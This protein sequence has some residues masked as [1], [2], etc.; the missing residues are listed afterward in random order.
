MA[1]PFETADTAQYV[2]W[3]QAFQGD[4]VIATQRERRINTLSQE[5][6]AIY[7]T[8]SGKPTP[9]DTWKRIY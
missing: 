9:S 5:V 8:S 2:N 3:F 1:T 4:K 7:N 6:K